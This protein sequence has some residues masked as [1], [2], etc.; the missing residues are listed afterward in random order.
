[1]S[2]QR[3]RDREIVRRYMTGET[4]VSIAATYGVTRE[5][6][7]QIA[8]KAGVWRPTDPSQHRPHGGG[9]RRR[10]PTE[11]N[12]PIYDAALAGYGVESAGRIAARFGVTKNVIIGHWTRQRRN[13]LLP[14][15]DKVA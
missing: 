4:L 14:A 9:G 10:G 15:I 13:G 8:V 2:G 6:V 3:D 1:M 5:R 12:R 7:R 11:A